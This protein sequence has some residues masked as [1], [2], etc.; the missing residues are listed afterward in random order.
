MRLFTIFVQH[1]SEIITG[2]H[3]DGTLRELSEKRSGM[4]P[5]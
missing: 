1:V 2:K 3:G 5:T 4:G